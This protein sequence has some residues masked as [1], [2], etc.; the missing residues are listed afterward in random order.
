[1]RK[2]VVGPLSKGRQSRSRSRVR[3]LCGN[4]LPKSIINASLGI[5]PKGFRAFGLRNP[6]HHTHF[7]N[8]RSPV[9]FCLLLPGRGMCRLP[10]LADVEAY[11]TRAVE[12]QHPGISSVK[13]N[14]KNFSHS[15]LNT[16]IF[17]MPYPRRLI[18]P[19]YRLRFERH[20]ISRQAT[21]PVTC[22][23]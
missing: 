11:Q 9:V 12:T 16:E 17:Y 19:R 15:L 2:C 23:Y 20:R 18:G 8:S 5:M 6:N 3:E 7:L 1:M 21:C 4:A 13:I 14:L 22:G 10:T